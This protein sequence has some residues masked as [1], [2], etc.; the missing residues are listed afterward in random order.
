MN[1]LADGAITKGGHALNPR[2]QLYTRDNIR[3]KLSLRHFNEGLRGAGI[4]TEGPD[5]LGPKDIQ[6]FANSLD[7]FLTSR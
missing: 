6:A 7:K 2:G 5:I 1:V 4:L 3:Q